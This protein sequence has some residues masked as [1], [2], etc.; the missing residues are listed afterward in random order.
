MRELFLKDLNEMIDKFGL[1]KEL[2]EKKLDE[3]FGTLEDH[4]FE[5]MKTKL[6][7]DKSYTEEYDKLTKEFSEI[8]KSAN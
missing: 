2:D 5:N 1:D 6:M 7:S 8:K 4:I 3:Y